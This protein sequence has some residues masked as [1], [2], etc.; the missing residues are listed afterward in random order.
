MTTVSGENPLICIVI[1]ATILGPY[2]LY[3]FP[4]Y[5]PH[6]DFKM[7]SSISFLKKERNVSYCPID[8]NIVDRNFLNV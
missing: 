1:Y 8:I 3:K 5:V 7:N 2:F 6:P 4:K